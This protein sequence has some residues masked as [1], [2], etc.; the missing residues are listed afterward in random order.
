MVAN[1]DIVLVFIGESGSGK[2]TCINY[3]ANFFAGTGFSQNTGY[4]KL[5]VVIPN[6]LFANAAAAAGH[7]DNE[8]NVYDKT[9]SQTIHC[10]EHDFVWT[11]DGN[12]MRVKV[13]DTPG[14]NDTDSQRDDN[15]IQEILG[16]MSKLPFI[17]AIIITINGT[18]SRLSTSVRST[19]DQLRSSLPDSIFENL[20]FILTNC[21]ESECNFDM[22]LINEYTPDEQ[23]IFHMQNSLFSVE[24]CDVNEKNPKNALRAEA[25]WKDSMETIADIMSKIQQTSAAS[26]QVFDDM[27]I[28]REQL[29]AHKDNLIDKQKSLLEI[30]NAL[31]I[32]RERLI[33]AQN[34]RN[35][36]QNYTTNKMIERI[37]I[38]K[39][40]YYSTIC[41]EH[42][43]VLVCHERCGLSYQPQLNLA[44]F[45]Q[46]AAADSSGNNCRHCK[47]GM[48]QHL[49]T[50]EIPVTSMVEIEEIIQ[51]KKTAF[52][53]ASQQVH[54]IQDQLRQL[55][56]ASNKIGNETQQCKQGILS[57]I[58]ALKSICS[59]FNFAEIMST[60]IEKLRQEAKIA[61]NL[62]AKAEFNNT[63]DAIQHLINH[64][65]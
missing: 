4:S 24:S 40:P 28:Q 63:A 46:C 52:D 53:N 47:C 45:T 44:H 29:M 13:V 60:T 14:F 51:S 25:N 58:N 17:T 19:L 15:N 49:H 30:M 1:S 39:K 31:R 64:L 36:N 43:K 6:R 3:F 22:K 62:Q 23:R 8:R 26:T 27:R 56:A 7:L 33:Y 41:T 50:Y 59:H 34:D 35:A 32:E 12:N 61:R 9:M 42:G 65:N 54:T 20:F 37:D 38:E 18:I 55:D 16:T 11:A 5:Q 48:N 21:T 10:K 2:S 57:S